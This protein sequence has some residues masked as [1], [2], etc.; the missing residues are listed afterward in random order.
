MHGTLFKNQAKLARPDLETH[1]A[2]LG[3]DMTKFKAAL[4]SGKFKAKVDAEMAAGN[5]I[6]ARGTPAFFINGRLF[7]GAQPLAAFKENID[8]AIKDADEL[9][10]AKHIKPAQ[11]YD[12]LMKEAKEGT[13]T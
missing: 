8:R 3:L 11:V 9:I 4:D 13:P 5:K 10:K 12:T 7:S 6:G 1:A 2:S